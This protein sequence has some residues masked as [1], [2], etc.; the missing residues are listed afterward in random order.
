MYAQTPNPYI[1][2]YLITG[3]SGKGIKEVYLPPE[4]PD[5]EVHFKKE[6]KFIR[7]EP[8]KHIKK[9]IKVLYAKSNKYSTYYD[10]D[11]V[12]PY[13]Q[14]I[15]EWEDQQWERFENGFWFWN[16]G[17]KTYLTPFYYWYLTEW[18]P[19]FGKPE[20]RETDKEITYWLLY[21]EEDPF[22]YGGLLNTIRRYGKSAIM[23][24]W[25]IWRTTRNFAHYS[26]CQGESDDKIEAF[27]KTHVL[28]P[29]RKLNGYVTPVYDTT[30]KQ[31]ADISFER[32]VSRGKEGRIDPDIDDDDFIDGESETEDLESY[33]D[34][35]DSNESAYDQAVLHTYL[36]EEPGKCHPKGTKVRMY[37]GTIKNVEEVQIG[38]LLR[39]DD[40]DPRHVLNTG[41]GRGKIYK[42]IPNSKVEPWYIN[43]HHILSCK[44]SGGTPFKG[45]KKGDVV[46]ISLKTYFS[47][48]PKK[49]KHLMCYRVGVEYPERQT[50]IHP[51]TLGL[52]LG[53]GSQSTPEI[54]NMEPEVAHWLNSKYHVKLKKSSKERVPIY[55]IKGGFIDSIKTEGLFKNKH[56]PN[57]YLIN[58]RAN[59]LQLLAGLI[60]TDGH[61]SSNPKR[62][63]QR[64]YEIVQKRKRLAEEIKEL[65]LSLGFYASIN[66]KKATM[67][68]KNKPTYEC[69]VYRVFIY[70]HNLYEIPCRVERKKMPSN[71]TTYNSKNPL[72]YGFTVEYDRVDDYY[73]FNISG[74]RLYL[75]DNY[76]VTHNTIRTSV[77]DR[78]TTV[79]PCLRRGKFIR[80][81]AL[82][83]T[84]VEH[85]NVLDRGG[86]AYQK[87]F[88]ES[89]F[90]KRNALGQ[91]DSGLYTAFLSGDCAYEGFFD[92]YGH[93]MREEARRSLL[94][95]RESKRKNPKDHAKIIR[96]YP[97]KVSEIFWVSSENCVF[98]A[99]ILQKRKLFLDSNTVP[100]YSRFKVEWKN[101]IRFSELVFSHDENG[102]F[103]S[104]WM[105]PGDTWVTLA[106]KVKQNSDGTYVPLNGSIFT[107]GLDPVDHRVAIQVS[108]GI[109][110]DQVMTTRR[111][112]PVMRVKRRYDP[113]VDVITDDESAHGFG[114]AGSPGFV[115]QEL[116][117]YRRDTEYPYKTGVTIGMIDERHHDAN[118]NFERELM[119][120]WLF[121]M[122]IMIE[123][124]KPGAINY[125][126]ANKCQDF[127]KMKYVPEASNK[128]DYQGEGTPANPMTINEYTDALGTMIEYYG[129]TEIF[130]EFNDDYLQF[131][132]AKTKEFDY[133]VSSGWTELGEKVRPKSVQL[134]VL[135]LLTIMPSWRNGKPVIR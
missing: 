81:K 30:S 36:M 53:D 35:R 80:G 91:T 47:L 12:S 99:T 79:K 2:L 90:D 131:N 64:H 69:M 26:G 75:L 48:S 63:T 59:R 114:E 100:L 60:D 130:P 32:P 134:P 128:Q 123:S 7:P 44:I 27:W 54:A 17:K 102:W 73:G 57:K 39:G 87:I 74:N 118:V 14:E 133:A 101:K 21:L 33:I 68:R 110:E 72:V 42:I 98:N 45:Y 67:K 18:V 85:M 103:K 77:N 13:A 107:A 84:T 31:T 5:N 89:D 124:A 125:F 108:T 29:F 28:K 25:M 38:E 129:H 135:D 112:K 41:Q 56:I 9:A 19:Y 93:P 109:G 111:S 23:G 86:K 71:I 88:Y 58:S 97:L 105:F 6:N 61:R 83:A 70:G 82:L 40:N 3:I 95:E 104:G 15:R 126:I 62:P 46:N 120:C 49:K 43:E 51:Y 34:W 16:R 127:L 10:P 66:P 122:E 37:D 24:A 96:Q 65:C 22:C 117:E 55:Y 78:W 116:L 92:D 52:W 20:Y 8:P 115:T 113:F 119:I 94:I 4:P 11:Y 76:T 132:P 106:N 50:Y 121:G 1:F